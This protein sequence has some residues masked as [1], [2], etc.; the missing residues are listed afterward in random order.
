M[1]YNGIIK[2]PVTINDV[3]EALGETSNDLAT[4][5]KSGNINILSKYKPVRLA[6]VAV[7]DTLNSDKSTWT[8]K[9]DRGWWLGDKNLEYGAYS[10]SAY[11]TIYQIVSNGAWKYNGPVGGLSSPY[12]L[13]DFAGYNIDDADSEFFPLQ[14]Y[15]P[16]RNMY[17]S[18]SFSVMFFTGSEPTHKDNVVTAEDIINMLSYQFGSGK[19]YPALYVVNET[20]GKSKYVSSSVP[21]KNEKAWDNEITNVTIDLKNTLIGNDDDIPITALGFKVDAGDVI[22]VYA[23]LTNVASVCDNNVFTRSI[24]FPKINSTGTG[25]GIAKQ[26]YTIEGASDKPA[27]V[28]K[29]TIKITNLN[30]STTTI[31]DYYFNNHNNSYIIKSKKFLQVAFDFSF[32]GNATGIKIRLEGRSNDDDNTYIATRY[33]TFPNY[34]IGSTQSVKSTKFNT[35]CYEEKSD[36]EDLN[37]YFDLNSGIPIEISNATNTSLKFPNWDVYVVFELDNVSGDDKNLIYQTEFEGDGITSD[38]KIYSETY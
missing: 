29:K 4:L 2:A 10:L 24:S 8:A 7:D 31:Y 21:L 34:V 16:E 27:E 38:G 36:A 25:F 18:S 3:K 6:K 19:V 26:S 37:S 17:T 12:R 30:L 35:E 1:I 14:V 5:C 11:D 22:S 23:L 9:G 32:T 13:T 15:I 20:K 28:V 33:V